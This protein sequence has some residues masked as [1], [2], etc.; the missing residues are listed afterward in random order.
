MK[1]TRI[2]SITLLVVLA[3]AL[4]ISVAAAQDGD[5]LVIGWEQEPPLLAPRSDLAFAQLMTNF[6]Q[7]D[8]WGFDTNNE[9]FPIMVAEIPS[10][11]NGMVVTLENGNTQVAYQLREGMTWS[12]GEPITS[13]D[14]AFWH[15]I[16]MDPAKGTF[17]RGIYPD[18]VE[19]FEVADD[20]NFTITYNTP[21]PDY[22]I[23]STAT[24][25]F[26]E[27]ILGPVL[28]AEGT[29]DNAP[30]FLGENAI[31]YGPYVLSEWLVGESMTFTVNANWDG[32]QPAFETVILR[33]VTDTA[34]MQNAL[35]VGEIDVAFNWSD[36]LAESYTAIENTEVF[37]TDGV[38]GDAIWMNV[39]NGGHP[40]LSDVNV[41]MA[42]IHAIDRATLAGALVGEGV[43]VPASWYPPTFVPEDVVPLEFDV[44]KANELLDAAGW[45]DSNE[46]G[47]RD[48]DGVEMVLRFYTTTR[49][50][51]I[52]YQT[53][54]QE[55]WTAVG[56]GAQLI[57]VPATILF[58]DFLERGIL[59][60]GDFDVAIFALSSNPLSPSG[61]AP[62][63]F[64]CDGT[65]TA[66]QPNGNNGW[67]FCDPEY[68]RLDLESATTVDPAARL[69]LAQGA[70]RAFYSG[71]FW[72][73]LYLRPTW[74]AIRT[75]RVDPATA[76]D[77]G[78]LSSNYFNK[79][80]LWQPAQ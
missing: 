5:V 73:G 72:H 52:D 16:V 51:R 1:F 28:E 64:G 11:E 9:I 76:R 75:D 60:T 8:I 27:H 40:S 14:C 59:D 57:P 77:L 49:Q 32:V 39:N 69:E 34:Q 37:K 6:F 30:F 55:Y 26:P 21:F 4:G 65:P 23:D 66:E 45:V 24:C 41:R 20:F 67:G 63:W 2:F 47:T 25:A 71:Q 12:D 70:I 43:L 48:K 33:F 18:V 10:P 78:V 7:R 38:F 15:E 29:I 35:E 46:S 61:T 50:I 53:A 42:L 54:I 36:D 17:Q 79:I 44:A 19:S 68:D 31:G 74:Y 80:E 13:A 56:V 62:E 22:L 58:A 3:L